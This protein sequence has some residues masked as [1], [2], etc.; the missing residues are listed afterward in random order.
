[1]EKRDLK[2]IFDIIIDYIGNIE[3]DESLLFK[4]F[5]YDMKVNV[6]KFLS[7]ESYEENQKILAAKEIEDKPGE[8]QY[9]EYLEKL[10]SELI[11]LIMGIDGKSNAFQISKLEITRVIYYFLDP[12]KYNQ[13]IKVLQE[14]LQKA[15][16]QK[17]LTDVLK[18]W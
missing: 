4:T 17:R 3:Y 10:R 2:K 15:K 14:A 5:K 9:S 1:M 13:N 16:K 8:S 11:N 18:W 7:P 12:N 6:Y